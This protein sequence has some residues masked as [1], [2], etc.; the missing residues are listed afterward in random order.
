MQSNVHVLCNNARNH[1]TEAMVQNQFGNAK[2]YYI[3]GGNYFEAIKLCNIIIL[4][5]MVPP[6]FGQNGFD[7]SF[8]QC[9]PCLHLGTLLSRPSFYQHLGHTNRSVTMALFVLL[10]SQHL[11][12]LASRNTVKQGKRENDKS[13]LS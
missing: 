5:P 9:F 4:A 6:V 2:D 11:G 10:F 1:I 13:T 12:I 3:I 8:F 7:L